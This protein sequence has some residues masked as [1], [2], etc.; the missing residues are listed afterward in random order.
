M[1]EGERVDNRL[2]ELEKGIEKLIEEI[3]DFRSELPLREMKQL[4]ILLKGAKREINT[5]SFAC[6]KEQLVKVFELTVIILFD[7][8]DESR[9]KKLSQAHAHALDLLIFLTSFPKTT[10]IKGS[11]YER[12][13]S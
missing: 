13:N 11:S 3:N 7:A 10:T 4:K 8:K 1:I 9:S 6:Q 5:Y 2:I 12:N